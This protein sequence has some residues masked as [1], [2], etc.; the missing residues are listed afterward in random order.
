MSENKFGG[1]KR[2]SRRSYRPAKGLG[3]RSKKKEHEA[4]D[5]REK[6]LAG[7]DGEEKIFDDKRHAKEIERAEN[8]AAGLPPE[9]EKKPKP[10]PTPNRKPANDGPRNQRSNKSRNTRKSDEFK[11]V[12]MKEPPP[13]GIVNSIKAAASKVIRKVQRM[14]KPKVSTHKEVIISAEAL[15]TRVAVTVEGRLEEFTIERTTEDRLVGSIFKGKVR[16]L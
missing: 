9:G 7:D 5:A 14:I 1:R 16:N 6:V 15:E 3:H 10:K 4:K 8:I 12:A 13:Q 2:S 11:P